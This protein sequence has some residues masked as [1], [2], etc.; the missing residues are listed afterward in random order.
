MR[1][2]GVPNFPDPDQ[3]GR[4]PSFHTGTSKQIS[5]RADGVCRHLLPSGG[6]GT[7]QQRAQKFVFALKVARCLRSHG[8]PTF[9]DPTTQGERIPPEIDTESPQFQSTETNC[10]QQARKALGLP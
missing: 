6:T 8:Y 1:R 5:A 2:H 4:F 3:Q 10:E 9:P 7:P